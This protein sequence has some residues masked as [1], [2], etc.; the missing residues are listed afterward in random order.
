MTDPHPE[1]P[2]AADRIDRL[3]ALGYALTAHAFTIEL[4]GD[5]L[6]V[7]SPDR[8]GYV[9]DVRCAHRMFDAGRLWFVSGADPLA[10]AGQITEALT[11]IKGLTAVRM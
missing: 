10:E 11:A 6:H 3:A 9:I 4:T 2:T 5:V 1:D 8:P 7:T